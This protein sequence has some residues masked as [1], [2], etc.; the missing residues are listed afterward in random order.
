MTRALL[1]PTRAKKG[2]AGLLVN[3]VRSTEGPI[4]GQSLAF[5]RTGT[6][7]IVVNSTRRA[8]SER[9]AS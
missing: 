1:A 7:E 6:Y 5:K 4:V 9:S 8:L 3:R 2:N